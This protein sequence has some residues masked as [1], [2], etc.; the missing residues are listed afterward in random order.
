MQH[1]LDAA[2]DCE[3]TGEEF[4]SYV[5]KLIA[6]SRPSSRLGSAQS[7]VKMKWHHNQIEQYVSRLDRLQGS[8]SLA[9]VLSLRTRETGNHQEVLDHLKSIEA[10]ND[11]SQ[12]NG[13]DLIRA[14]SLLHGLVQEQ[15]GPEL[16]M[17]QKQM[18]SCMEDIQKIRS[19]V[20]ET[21]EG[22][23]LRWLDFRQRT[24]RFEEVEEAHQTT[25]DWI[26]RKPHTNTLWHD[27]GAHLSKAEV[28]KPYFINGKAGSGKSTLMKYIISNQQTRER[29]KEWAGQNKLLSPYFFFWNV[30]TQLQKSHTGMLRSLLHSILTHYNDLIPAV[31]PTLY[32]EGIPISNYEPPSYVELK[33]AFE[34]LKVRSA[35][36]LRICI[37][38][39]GVD[40]FEGD[41]RDMSTFLCSIA[42][43]A[44]KVVVSSRPINACLNVFKSC[45]TLRLQDLTQ[46]DMSVFIRD[47]LNT[48][49][50]M[51]ELRI[52]SPERAATLEA[53]IQEKAEGVFLWV[54]IVTGLLLRGLDDGDDFDDL[55]PKLRALPSDLRELYTRM[56]QKMPSEY[57]VQASQMFQIFE[58]WRLHGDEKPLELL[59]LSYAIQ[60]PSTALTLR[61]NGW[62]VQIQS[63]YC[64]R[65]GAR[66]RSRCCGLLELRD[67]ST[68]SIFWPSTPVVAYLHRSVAEFVTSQEVW[69]HMLSLTNDM[70][71]NPGTYIACGILSILRTS[72]PSPDESKH[73]RASGISDQIEYNKR[74]VDLAM[75]VCR[76]NTDIEDSLI[77]GYMEAVDKIMESTSQGLACDS[78]DRQDH[79]VSLHWSIRM[80]Q[81]CLQSET[82]HLQQTNHVPLSAQANIRSF[83]AYNAI[84]PY[85]QAVNRSSKLVDVEFLILFA[86]GSWV[87]CEFSFPHRLETLQFL[88]QILGDRS[89][90]GVETVIENN[91][92]WEHAVVIA[93]DFFNCTYG[94]KSLIAPSN[95]IAMSGAHTGSLPLD[96]FDTGESWRSPVHGWQESQHRDP[97]GEK[98]ALNNYHEKPIVVHSGRKSPK[99]TLG[100]RQVQLQ[101][102]EDTKAALKM[103][104]WQEMQAEEKEEADLCYKSDDLPFVE[105][106]KQVLRSPAG[107]DMPIA[108]QWIRKRTYKADVSKIQ[109]GVDILRLFLS[110][111]DKPRELLNKKIMTPKRS[112]FK[113]LAILRKALAQGREKAEV[114]SSQSEYQ[115][116]YQLVGLPET[117]QS[118]G[119]Y[120]YSLT[121]R[122]TRP[123]HSYSSIN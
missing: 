49:S 45:P 109:E 35:S 48:H 34:R 82:Q 38:I 21:R 44:I 90:L 50:M 78:I 37:F 57:Q 23:I 94:R 104:R 14:L 10:G 9:T 60:Q 76:Q 93:D 120:I 89:E 81:S 70:K 28:S 68:A 72:Y 1:L 47:R 51:A 43:S 86:L 123:S 22:E 92:L 15:S 67:V 79:Q 36:F 65:I 69:G 41:H 95:G 8:L 74:I 99:S 59:L 117:K 103:E 64:E 106:E 116:L 19:S 96:T 115:F 112:T 114:W 101:A 61:T 32:A 53:E 31:Y 102:P 75:D 73:L 56:M 111:T 6:T 91:T 3:K 16:D 108:P 29:L 17:L 25:F 77:F 24:W 7:S 121:S 119:Q 27:F 80:A 13:D 105:N 39:D 66:V 97:N 46:D 5:D 52:E 26:F 113:P 98:L 84:I 85:L 122:K 63:S 88:L 4:I 12:Q 83:A 54:R 100:G 2:L 87:D 30:G 110:I 62:N 33:G 42:S 11:A 18:D 55:L 58:W 71:F 118:T 40:E 20:T 107:Y